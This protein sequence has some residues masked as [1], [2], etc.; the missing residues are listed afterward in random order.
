MVWRRYCVSC[1]VYKYI[2]GRNAGHNFLRP[3]PMN[4]NVVRRVS[5]RATSPVTV[6]IPMDTAPRPVTVSV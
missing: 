1:I 4:L 6:V 5:E 3:H 2:W